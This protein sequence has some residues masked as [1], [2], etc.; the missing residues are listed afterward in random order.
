[1]ITELF[2]GEYMNIRDIAKLAGVAVSTVSRVMNNHQDVGAET[3]E[4]I[5]RVM[6]ETGY[7]PNSNARNLK[8]TSSAAIGVMIKGRDNPFF[9]RMIEAIE[10]EIT[11]RSYS[12]ILHYNHDSANDIEAA[13]E[14][15]KEKRLEGLICLGGN[16]NHI[17]DSYLLDLNTPLVLAS[18]DL[19]EFASFNGFSSVGVANEK[20]A[21]MA[22][23]HLLG[24]GH[25]QIGLITSDES[26]TCTGMLRHKGYQ[27]A[28][29]DHGLLENPDFIGSGQYTFESGYRVAGELLDRQLGLTALFIIS[30]IM[31]IGA[32]RAIHE[33]GLRI[34]QDIAVVGFDGLEY[35]AFC[36]PTLT[37]VQQPIEEIGM[38]SAEL[39]FA[40]IDKKTAHQH[41]ILDTALI[42]RQSTVSS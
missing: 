34:P 32:M 39:L 6:E 20:A 16:F 41:L 17:D 31:A 25:R 22:V 26:E 42:I 28:L 38:K 37:T 19:D 29:K 21:Y 3:R 40:L 23:D 27:Q 13:I 2:W 35:A 12:M 18:T 4:R 11:N 30:D 14:L 8:R 36:H 9:L 10:N 33:R 15:I 5:L 1:M 7:V 24:L